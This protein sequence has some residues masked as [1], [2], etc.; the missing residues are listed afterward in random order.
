MQ[1]V[2]A[3]QLVLSTRNTG[4]TSEITISGPAGAAGVLRASDD[5]NNWQPVQSFVL[6]GSPFV[7]SQEANAR[8]AFFSVSQQA[9]GLPLPDL[10][11]LVNSVFVPGEGFNTVQYSPSGNLGAIY[12]KDRDLVFLERNASGATSESIVSS[13]GLGI[14][15]AATL[16]YSPQR[17]AVLLFDSSSVA[18]VFKASGSTVQHLKKNGGSWSS[19]ETINAPGTVT[20]L[21]ADIGRDNS[22]HVGVLANGSLYYAGSRNSWNWTTV[23]SVQDDPWWMP[24][25]FSRRWFSMA[26]DSQ[27]AAHFVYRPTFDFSRHPE[28]YMRAN[29]K[30]KY[31]SNRTGSWATEIVR[32]PDDISGEAGSGESIAIGPNDLPAIASWY[33]ERGDGGSSQWSRLQFYEMDGSGQWVRS[34]VTSRPIGYIAGD[35]EKGT[36]AYPYLRYDPQGRPHIIFTDHAAEHFP[37]QNEYA[38]HVR[39]AVRNGSEW[40]IDTV[41]AQTAPLQQQAV[42]PAFAVN[43]GELAVM[44]LERLTAWN[45]QVNP[46]VATSTYKTHLIVRSSN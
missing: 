22:F 39:H 37:Y 11:T 44:L 5:L 31:A 28:G 18:H 45:T 34:E 10:S 46:Q 40:N 33:N 6:T 24:G 42:F 21:V 17:P 16:L 2:Q 36:G 23:D 19:V 32:E 15:L 35:G 27:G 29:T 43:N 8:R 4:S 13:D 3:Q 1:G 38:G 30:L 9:A 25:S 7:Y 41:Y 26:V 20:R 12:W 14:S